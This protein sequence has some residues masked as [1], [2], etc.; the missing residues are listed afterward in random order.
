MTQD[1]EREKMFRSKMT[2]SVLSAAL[3][4]ACTSPAMAFYTECS[5]TKD[6]RLLNRPN[7]WAEPRF[8][9]V[10]KGDKVAFRD[11]YQKWWFV[12]HVVGEAPNMSAD[13]GWISENVLT[14]CQPKDGT[15]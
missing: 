5:V 13:Y 8:A 12:L 6:T 11:R 14:D 7:G 4:L 10:D 2:M 9:Q 1:R 15:P 3:A